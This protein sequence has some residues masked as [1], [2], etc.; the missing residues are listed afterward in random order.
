LHNVFPSL[1]VSLL[2]EDF[3][4]QGI[5]IDAA[6]SQDFEA[7]VPIKHRPIWLGFQ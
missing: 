7:M 5:D 1:W 2:G 4:G 6:I 3:S